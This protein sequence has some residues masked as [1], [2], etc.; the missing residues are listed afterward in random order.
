MKNYLTIIRKSDF[1]DLFK[2][3]YLY[4]DKSQV[5]E[6]DG[7]VSTLSQNI[8]L[9][10][11]LFERTNQFEY[12]FTVLLVYF[13]SDLQYGKLNIE[14][15]QN[16]FA[17]DFDA[18]RE[19]E[20]SYDPRIRI[21]NPIW[22]DTVIKLQERFSY[23][24]AKKGAQNIWSILKIE[25]PISEIA[26]FFPDNYIKEIVYEVQNE[27]R[28]KGDLSFWIYL[29]RYE[30]HGFFPKN[31][32]GYFMDLVNVYINTIG[33]KEYPSE[34][35]EETGIYKRILEFQNLNMVNLIERLA[36][37][38]EGRNFFDKVDELSGTKTN[39]FIIAILFLIL[40]N[41]Y[42]NGFNLKEKEVLEYSS[43][44]FPEEINYTL[45]LLGI[46]LG[47]SHTFECL[48]DYLP[49]P[50]FKDIV[51][52]PTLKEVEPVKPLKEGC[53]K[54]EPI[55]QNNPPTSDEN[56]GTV[57]SDLTFATL[58][59][60]IGNGNELEVKDR[61]TKKVR[62]PGTTGNTGTKKVKD[63]K[64]FNKLLR[65]GYIPEP[66]YGYLNE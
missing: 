6:F 21:D 16:I 24:D 27:Q 25:Q 63:S 3:G 4:I 55:P 65:N 45:Y 61:P 46:F 14:D 51:Q 10:D 57:N 41:R 54:T 39:S 2:F 8:E 58:F 7:N 59:D 52:G 64:H 17:L 40:K 9:R 48:Y 12:S 1:T 36:E 42:I 38:T 28:P 26:Y 47:N 31:T 22:P 66:K 53:D 29:L 30:R 18:K 60:E 56:I 43:Q 23:E 13:R 37:T 35:I 19:I 33:H 15:V 62:K 34:A 5:F 44:K 49:L 50:V 32:S 20:I 11:R